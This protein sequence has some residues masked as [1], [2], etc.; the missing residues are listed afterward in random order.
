MPNSDDEFEP[1]DVSDPD[2]VDDLGAH[3]FTSICTVKIE[4]LWMG[5]GSGSALHH[6]PHRAVEGVAQAAEEGFVE[7]HAIFSECSGLR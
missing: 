3:T 2:A 1:S 7:R 5:L 6:S 4:P